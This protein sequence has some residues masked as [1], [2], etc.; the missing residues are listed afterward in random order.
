MQRLPFTSYT[1]IALV[2]ELYEKYQKDP[3]LVDPSWRYFFSGMEFALE[4]E[5]PRAA[6][7][8]AALRVYSLI[9]AY[10]SYGHLLADIDPI[11]A[12]AIEAVPELELKNL[13]FT[14][15]DLAQAFPTCGLMAEATAPL[16]A[17][18]DTL[19][20]I[21]CGTVGVEYTGLQNAEVERWLQAEVE[22]SHFRQELPIE[23]KRNILTAL[24]KA[25]LFEIF[26]HT[27]YVGQKRFSLE[28]GENLIPILETLLN[29]GS[30][31]GVE[32][33][34]LGMAHRGRLNVLAN[35]L[36]KA[37]AH[38]FHEFED[39]LPES[40]WD[41]SGDVKYHK[42]FSAD[43]TTAGGKRLHVN[44]AANPSHLESVDPVVEGKTRAKQVQRGD[45]RERRKVIP[46]LIHGDA[47]LAAQGV[48]YET[49]QMCRLAGYGVGGTIHIVVN[50]QIGFT[51]LPQD[52]R[53]TR[54]CTDVARAFGAPV[55]H[56]NGEDAQACCRV[57]RLAMQI[58]YQFHSDVFI[59]FNCYRKYGHNEADEPAFTQ[60]A[61][62][63][64]IRSKQSPRVIYRDHLIH[65]GVIERQV[66]EQLET[67]FRQA[68]Q[69]ELDSIKTLKTEPEPDQTPQRWKSV[70][71]ANR[72]E[73]P[74]TPVVTGVD[75][76]T[77]QRLADSFTRL[78]EGFTLH[79]KILRMVEERRS[80]VHG[81]P[82]DKRINWGTAEHLAFAS[83][84]DEGVSVRLSGQDAQRGTFNHRHAMWKD[85]EKEGTYFPLN[86]L[87][88]G[89][90]RFDVYNSP[91]SEYAVM[92]FEFGYS[93]A[94]PEALVIW[95][96]QYGDFF[97]AGQVVVDQYICASEQK[98][99]Q[100]SGVVVLLPHGYEG[101]GPEHSS[102]RIERFLQLA[103]QGNM[104]IVNPSTP[105]Q[106]FHLLRRQVKRKLR[107]PLIVF[108][109]KSLLGHPQFA[110]SLNELVSG[111]FQELLD[112]PAAIMGQVRRLAFCSGRIYYDLVE[113]RE[114]R[115]AKEIALIRVEQLYPFHQKLARELIEK[116]AGFN[117]CVW[118]QDEPAN[119]GG[120]D[121]M[122]PLLRSVLPHPM[123]PIYIGRQSSAAPATGSLRKHRAQQAQ[124]FEQLFGKADGK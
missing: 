20:R 121:F 8:S 98:W 71:E 87:R 61:E 56:V 28:G 108:T 100:I 13:G 80:S 51:T 99:G 54:Y 115:G 2:E 52:G 57:A 107:K 40:S 39:S 89:Q 19:K 27:K 85:Q 119:M 16:Q 3:E 53:S 10:R 24:N 76:A 58:R 12:H 110:S 79:R 48:V 17:I 55:F 106:F 4:R 34:V 91:L 92:G 68:L 45:D 32:E 82:A 123:E 62:Y 41:I 67:E 50:N 116:Y 30:R 105:A 118:V 97:N 47:A 103:A 36:N 122:R 7:G 75:A 94:Y 69:Q 29:E 43:V 70:V 33:I 21:Y 120:W 117:D 83:V 113:E 74:F 5:Q 84:L 9:E 14:D 22:S 95:E 96:A 72:G 65:A 63:R 49:M 1:N 104:Q 88:E 90:G 25:E 109:P 101:Q 124:I 23:E 60:P 64:L 6:P 31:R 102:G 26:L 86:H 15:G 42:G 73:D 37:Y 11:R 46:I 59:D 66:A 77:L 93:L 44:M 78:P 18:V 112:D 111:Q 114:K 35:I 38:I 81:D